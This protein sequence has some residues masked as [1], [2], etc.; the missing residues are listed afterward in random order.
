M[1]AALARTIAATASPSRYASPSGVCGGTTHS[2]TTST[3]WCSPADKDCLKGFVRCPVAAVRCPVA[4]QLR[5]N[6][7]SRGQGRDRA[8]D[9]GLP[10]P[11]E[12]QQHEDAGADQ[13]TTPG[14]A[15]QGSQCGENRRQQQG[16]PPTAMEKGRQLDQ[17]EERQQDKEGIG[18]EVGRPIAQGQGGG[19]GRGGGQRQPLRPE[20]RAQIAAD[21]ENGQPEGGGVDQPTRFQRIDADP[22]AGRQQQGE[23]GRPSYQRVAREIPPALSGEEVYGRR[24][25][26]NGVC[27]DRGAVG[28]GADEDVRGAQSSED[29]D[30]QGD[31]GAPEP[32]DPLDGGT[33]HL[34][35]NS[36][37]QRV[38]PSWET[39]WPIWMR[40][41]A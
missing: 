35:E 17:G 22:T 26:K 41:M 30:E 24:E 32:G 39:H 2:R 29:D 15:G 11:G 40:S 14:I 38:R 5:A 6:T 4:A 27:V 13:G 12:G 25:K 19:K 16:R 20:M 21:G 36:A 10:L 34:G 33:L 8:K 9:E 23:Q 7:A 37:S 18:H 1:T 3:V 31:A 28:S